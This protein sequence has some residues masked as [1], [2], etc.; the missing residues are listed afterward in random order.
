MLPHPCRYC[1]GALAFTPGLRHQ[2]YTASLQTY[3]SFIKIRLVVWY[4]RS[5]R[6][7]LASAIS[8]I[9]FGKKMQSS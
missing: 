2:R 3:D 6:A 7:V 1:A 8:P 5:Y 4:Y 9:S